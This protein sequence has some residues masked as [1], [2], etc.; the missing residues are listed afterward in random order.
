MQADVR[1]RHGFVLHEFPAVDPLTIVSGH[2]TGTIL[3]YDQ[4]QLATL[5]RAL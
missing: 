3:R 5:R 1:A 2:A 4:R